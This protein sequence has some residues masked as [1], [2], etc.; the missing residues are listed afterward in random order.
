MQY[1]RRGGPPTRKEAP[2]ITFLLVPTRA[3][4]SFRCVLPFPIDSKISFRTRNA[5]LKTPKIFKYLILLIRPNTRKTLWNYI[6]CKIAKETIY[7]FWKPTFRAPRPSTIPKKTIAGEIC[8]P[9]L[10]T[11]ILKRWGAGNEAGTFII[12]TGTSR[13][14][15]I[16]GLYNEL[17]GGALLMSLQGELTRFRANQW[18]WSRQRRTPVTATGLTGMN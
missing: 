2:L 13:L 17:P 3:P 5:W 10:L 4:P 9:T 8:A 14:I 16:Y 12:Y 18:Q 11:H 1:A 6:I 15:G 7:V